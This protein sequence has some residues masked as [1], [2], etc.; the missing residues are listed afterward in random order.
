M[1]V[2]SKKMPTTKKP[3]TSN[4]INYYHYIDDGDYHYNGIIDS[5][6]ASNIF[7]KL[8]KKI[9]QSTHTHTLTH[10]LIQYLAL[11]FFF[12]H[13]LTLSLA[14]SEDALALK[15]SV[16]KVVLPFKRISLFLS[17]FII[18]K[19]L[20]NSASVARTHTHSLMDDH[21]SCLFGILNVKVSSGV[22][23]QSILMLVSPHRIHFSH[24]P[25]SGFW[26]V[27]VYCYCCLN[28]KHFGWIKIVKSKKAVP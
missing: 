10:P 2:E 5:I 15:I 8:E 23:T 12:T 18:W 14:A 7:S 26:C 6:K 4:N 11:N 3:H 20:I 19:N 13:T 16:N 17:L 9:D 1:K 24:E 22:L 27:F 25:N 28:L 21:F